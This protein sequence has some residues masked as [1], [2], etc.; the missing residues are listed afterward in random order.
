[1]TA[2]KKTIWPILL[3]DDEWGD[4]QDLDGLL[5]EVQIRMLNDLDSNPEKFP[6][7]IPSANIRQYTSHPAQAI[8]EMLETMRQEQR[9]S[10]IVSD[11]H[12]KDDNSESIFGEDFLRIIHGV[13][14]YCSSKDEDD[15]EIPLSDLTQ[16]CSFREMLEL[17]SRRADEEILDF[18]ES[19]FKDV[20]QYME[21]VNYYFGD[22]KQHPLLVMLCGNPSGANLI[23]I[24]DHVY[25]IGKKISKSPKGKRTFCEKDLLYILGERRI[26]PEEYITPTIEEHP[27]L[28]NGIHPSQ[29]LHKS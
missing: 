28:G 25:M 22:K 9:Y 18:M 23:G 1:M 5:E 16:T 11:N 7:E 6:Y 4:I 10:A 13:P 15:A 2:Q 29:Q 27:R 19:N 12:M 14:V 17:G 20:Q 24:E 26:L 21:M 3:V 8:E